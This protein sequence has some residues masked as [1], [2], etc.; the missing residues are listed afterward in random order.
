MTD[1]VRTEDELLALFAD[2]EKGN[3]T[4][5]SLRDFVVTMFDE[6]ARIEGQQAYIPD[7]A[8][9]WANSPPADMQEALDRL[10][11]LVGPVPE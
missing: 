1:T 10:A 6:D 3:I 2:N 8:V 11:K 9:L 5:Q 4:S 7:S